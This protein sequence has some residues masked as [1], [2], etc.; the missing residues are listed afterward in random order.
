VAGCC[1]CGD[2]SLGSCATELVS[3]QLTSPHPSYT[4]FQIGLPYVFCKTANIVTSKIFM[5]K[6]VV[7]I[8]IPSCTHIV[9]SHE[10]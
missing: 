2:E 7:S 3:L 8:M 9:N 10:S 4:L 1:E 5:V 6:F